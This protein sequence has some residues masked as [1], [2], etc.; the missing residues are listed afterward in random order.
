[1]SISIP[2]RTILSPSHANKRMGFLTKEI[3]AF[4][5]PVVMELE[6]Q[7]VAERLL[8]LAELD[9]RESRKVQVNQK[10]EQRELQQNLC[11]FSL[12]APKVT[13][14]NGLLSFLSTRKWFVADP[15]AKESGDGTRSNILFVP[16]RSGR[17]PFLGMISPQSCGRLKV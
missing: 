17:K 12:L 15:I 6:L 8:C 7:V 1:M 14:H 9:G 3:R 5:R 2:H 10:F 16:L 13:R 4:L 11:H